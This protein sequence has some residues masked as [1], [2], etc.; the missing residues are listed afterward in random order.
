[1]LRNYRAGPWLAAVACAVLLIVGI[2]P[3]VNIA[4][5]DLPPRPNPPA[6]TGSDGGKPPAGARI[7]LRATFGPGWPWDQVHW[8]ELW[9]GVE[10]QS[11]E[12]AWYTVAGWQ[13]TLDGVGGEENGDIVG[14]KAWWVYER[15]DGRLIAASEPFYLPELVNQQEVVAV[16]LRY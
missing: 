10:W 8:Q 9:T 3:S 6:P 16:V 12:G 1:M 13:G 11:A 2:S 15:R 7:A 14:E 4:R 5:A